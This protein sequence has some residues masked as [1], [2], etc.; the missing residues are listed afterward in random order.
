MKFP[1]FYI[2]LCCTMLVM[3]L[4]TLP[5]FAQDSDPDGFGDF[6]GDN[7]PE[8]PIDGG[9]SLLLAAGIGYG[10]KKLN[11]RRKQKV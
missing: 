9:V 11:D 4:S 5:S 6:T 10:I 2:M 3:L 8:A 7:E 1:N